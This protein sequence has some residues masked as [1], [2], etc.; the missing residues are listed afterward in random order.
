V[1]VA[2]VDVQGDR[3]EVVVKGY[4]A[5]EESWLIA[6]TQIHGD[7]ARE[8]VWLELDKFLGQEF[9]HESGQRLRVELTVV[10]SGGAHTE[11]VYR[12]VGARFGRRVFAIKGG[13][14]A[15]RPLVERPSVHNR[16][17]VPLFVL[18]V[19][20][21][22]DIVLSR[23][24]IPSPGPGFVHLPDWVDEEYVAQLTAEK[25]IRKYVKGRGAVREWVKLRE[26]NEAL[27]LEV[28]ALAAL[29]I[30]GAAFLRSLPDRAAQF[31]RVVEKT[32]QPKPTTATPP[33]WPGIPR[34][35]GGWVNSWRS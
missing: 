10:D 27:D 9:E 35:P 26:R 4:G 3:L 25:A 28:Y 13:N 34:R 16:Y 32:E 23:L 19:D 33:R 22:K 30:G 29:Y 5:A 2:A 8:A 1:L 24:R 14:I 15:G 11:H 7:P 6:F 12:Y 18:C 31:A 17:R 20:T 21:G